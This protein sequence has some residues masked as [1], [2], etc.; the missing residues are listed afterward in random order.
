[1]LINKADALIFGSADVATYYKKIS[2]KPFCIIQNGFDT[3]KF[4]VIDSAAKNYDFIY[5]GRLI[6]TK[7]VQRTLELIGQSHS[8]AIVGDGPLR[9]E[10]ADMSSATIIGPVENDA[11]PELLNEAKFYISMSLT[12]GCPKCVYEAILCGLYPVL[13]RIPAHA[14]I[15]ED[16]GYGV[17]L[18]DG[19]VLPDLKTKSVNLEKLKI[20]RS[21]YSHSAVVAREEEFMSQFLV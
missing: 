14:E 15:V 4:K 20:F 21:K 2:A 1:M 8:L 12:E 11:L 7:N 18:G 9:R 6:K 19:D 17:L 13:S 10:L 16:L 3:E 5:V